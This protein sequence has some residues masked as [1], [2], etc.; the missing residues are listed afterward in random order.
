MYI[1]ALES[2][3]YG[4]R[5]NLVFQ[6]SREVKDCS[7]AGVTADLFRPRICSGRNKFASGYVP[8]SAD[9]ANLFRYARYNSPVM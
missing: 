8:E 1:K 2:A 3:G 7:I 4:S 5:N 9:N 6:I